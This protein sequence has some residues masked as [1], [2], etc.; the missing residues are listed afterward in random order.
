MIITVNA[1]NEYRTA[2]RKLYDKIIFHDRIKYAE[3]F[4][5]KHDDKY[6]F[7]LMFYPCGEPK[8]I[9]CSTLAEAS[10]RDYRDSYQAKI[11]SHIEWQNSCDELIECMHLDHNSVVCNMHHNWWARD[12]NKLIEK[13]KSYES[14]SSIINLSSCIVKESD[15]QT[16]N[17]WKVS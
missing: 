6:G 11:F 7:V 5:I 3:Y 17:D 12:K 4:V 2:A 16:L 10:Y 15:I 1:S 14:P 8:C 13:I 9:G